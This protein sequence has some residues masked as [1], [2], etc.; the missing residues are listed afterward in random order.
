MVARKGETMAKTPQAPAGATF[1]WVLIANS[2]RARCF[3][4][5]AD[6]GAMREIES[7]VHPQS[8]LKGEALGHDRGGQVHKGVAST[9]F[10]PHT[11]PHDK[12][13]AA[14]AR[15]L[16]SYLEQAA[17]ARRF[18]TLSL[19]A[20]AAF[21]GELRAL[22]GPAARKLLRGGVPLDLTACEG[23]DLEHRVTQA[24]PSAAAD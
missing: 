17:L 19:V 14:F 3:V 24:L 13:H 9:Q 20:S 16:A 5:D 21:L 18:Q 11:D 23:A 1:D 2:A 15:E 22:L 10:A 4:R 7:F 12:E 8:R 6:N